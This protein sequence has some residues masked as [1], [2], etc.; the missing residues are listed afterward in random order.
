MKDPYQAGH[1][2]SQALSARSPRRLGIVM[3]GVGIGICALNLLLIALLG[4]Y[5]GGLFV[6]GMPAVFIGAWTLFTGRTQSA[7]PGKAP[8]WWTLGFYASLALGLLS[9]LGF[10]IWIPKI[11][12]VS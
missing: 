9:G 10:A 3:I 8:R 5:F 12:G 4:I 2:H 6:L 11:P 1:E 7:S